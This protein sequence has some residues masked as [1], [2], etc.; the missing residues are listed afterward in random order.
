MKS[1]STIRVLLV[2]DDARDA[3][4]VRQS[5]VDLAGLDVALTHVERLADAILLFREEKFDVILLD[6]GLPDS[7]GVQSFV[8]LYDISP[9]VPILVL[10]A[11]DNNG[12]ALQVMRRGA[13][14]YVIKS[15]L[16]PASLRRS[17]TYGIERH[18]IADKGRTES[19]ERAK[20]DFLAD[21]SHQLRT[22]LN[23]VIGFSELLVDEKVGALNPEQREYLNDILASGRHLLDLMIDIVDL[24]KEKDDL[25]ARERAARIEVAQAREREDDI[26]YRIQ[27]TMLIDQPPETFPGVRIGALS[28]PS[29]RIDGDFYIFINH[30]N[31]SLDVIVGDVM[32]KGTPA[33]LLAAATKSHFLKALGDLMASSKTKELPEPKEVATS[34]H[35]SVVRHLIDLESFVTLCYARLNMNTRTLDFVDCGHTGILQWHGGTG[36]CETHHGSD[37]PMGVQEGETYDQRSVAFEPGDLFLLYSDGVTEARNPGGEMFGVDRLEEFI[38][39]H[40]HL[41]APAFVEAI[42]T[43]VLRFAESDRLSDDLT[44]VAIKPMGPVQHAEIDISSELTQLRCARR[45]VREFCGRAADPLLDDDSLGALELAVTEAASNIII[46]AY[47]RRVDQRIHLKAESFPGCVSVTLQHSGK[48]FL[49]SPPS[50]LPHASRESGF[51]VYLIDHNVDG[52]RYYR[53]RLGR[54]CIALVKYC[55]F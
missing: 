5:L 1:K 22:P 32:G 49:P 54:N 45:F 13:Q 43:T 38:R 4:L 40:A 50:S 48:P 9:G 2:E 34:A 42:R 14:D 41:E 23:S 33:A 6:L 17:I 55:N 21:L 35:A 26:S 29:Q 11:R 39:S 47:D 20:A 10:G 16:D 18:K 3:L 27:Q 8:R 24:T 53:D 30:R 52:V 7:T 37:L 12:L 44:C 31:R 15:D 28:V 46:H 25:L 51:G 36:R 19:G